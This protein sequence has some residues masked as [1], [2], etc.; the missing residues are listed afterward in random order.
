MPEQNQD[1]E[2]LDLT[3]ATIRR[4]VDKRNFHLGKA[5]KIQDRIERLAKSQSARLVKK[6]S[7]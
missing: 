3:S 7:N 6:H 5:R 1:T 2:A 4:L